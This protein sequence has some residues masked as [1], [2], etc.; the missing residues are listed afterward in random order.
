MPIQTYKRKAPPTP[1]V[2]AFKFTHEALGSGA[3]WPAWVLALT[4]TSGMGTIYPVYGAGTRFWYFKSSATSV[5]VPIAPN[6]VLVN[7][8]GVF[9][10]L[11]SPI[12]ELLFEPRNT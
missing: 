11:P 8:S 1:I 9:T 7:E 2:F 3:D 6:D 5:A 4:P 12:F 10:L